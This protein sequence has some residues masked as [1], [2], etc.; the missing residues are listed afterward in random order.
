MTYTEGASDAGTG[1]DSK[2]DPIHKQFPLPHSPEFSCI[3]P[4]HWF[5]YWM[6]H[7]RKRNARA[8]ATRIATLMQR[9]SRL[10][11]PPSTNA[12]QV[13]LKGLRD[14]PR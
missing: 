4:K 5:H 6:Q 3:L 10:S 7:C 8:A 11:K 13:V 12:L 1:L 9:P 14:W 2:H